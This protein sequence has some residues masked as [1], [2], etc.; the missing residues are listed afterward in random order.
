MAKSR[1]T[2]TAESKAEAVRRIIETGKGLAEISRELDL[3]EGL[4]RS[5]ETALAA[6][7][8]RAF[9]GKGRPPAHEEGLRRLRA[10]VKRP[11]IERDLLERA[12][13]SFA[14]ESS[15]G[16][17]S[18][19][20]TGA[21]GRSGCRG[22]G[23]LRQPSDPRRVGRPRA[24]MRRR[25]HGQADARARPRGRDQAE[26][27]AH[28]RLEPRP[29]AAG[30]VP[31]RQF[32]PGA[33]DLFWTADITYVAAHEGWLYLA[34]AEDLYSRR[35]VGRLMSERNDVRLAV[36][37]LEMVVA[38]R[39]LGEGL[40]PHS[41]RGGQYASEHCQRA[42]GRRGIVCSMSRR[43]N[44]RDNAPTESFFASLKKELVHGEDLASRAELFEYIEVFYNRTR[45][46]SSPGYRSPIE[47]ER[48]G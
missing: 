9:L 2:S 25:H 29:P 6:D 8:D 15:R 38:S 3:G 17:T 47:Y 22:A 39:L 37:A 35:I 31:D 4:L 40:A 48:A 32:K 1:G 21:D 7:G 41:G 36:D 24:A 5:W 23:P 44:S 12:T 19:N 10:E 20:A 43:A 30:N 45:C 18:S 46:H 34:A 28:D 27:P 11:T 14:G 26:V 42:L 13:A 16:T 33:A